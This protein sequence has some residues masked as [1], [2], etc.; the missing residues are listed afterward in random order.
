MV[1]FRCADVPVMALP[2]AL[3]FSKAIVQRSRAASSAE[4]CKGG[5]GGLGVL[6]AQMYLD[7]S[8]QFHLGE[9]V[10]RAA[11]VAGEGRCALAGA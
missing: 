8:L 5:S 2:V 4:F 1:R 7:A 10:G 6:L 3:A 11:G 9:F